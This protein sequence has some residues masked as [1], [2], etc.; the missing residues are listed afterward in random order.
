MPVVKFNVS[1]M[2]IFFYNFSYPRGAGERIW[3]QQKVRDPV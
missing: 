1:Y 3:P 2:V